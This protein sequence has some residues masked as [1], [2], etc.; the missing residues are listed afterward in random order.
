VEAGP[1][2]GFK[3]EHPDCNRVFR[4]KSGRGVHLNHAHKDWSDSRLLKESCPKAKKSRW[5]EEEKRLLARRVAA[6]TLESES[7][8]L[9]INQALAPFFPDRTIEA[10]KGIRKKVEH[11]R[12]VSELINEITQKTDDPSSTLDTSQSDPEMERVEKNNS[13]DQELEI[14]TYIHSLADIDIVGINVKALNDICNKIMHLEKQA[15]SEMIEMYVRDI[16]P[17]NYRNK[18]Q[19]EHTSTKLSSKKM[20]RKKYARVQHL[21]A[22]DRTRA[23]KAIDADRLE[24]S[25][26]LIPIN[27]LEPYW[28]A[29]VT[30]ETDAMPEDRKSESVRHDLW[31]PILEIELRRA[32]P[33]NKSAPGP[34]GITVRE[35]KQTPVSVLHRIFNIFMVRGGLPEFLLKSRTIFIDKKKDPTSPAD[36]RPISITPVLT[37]YFHEIIANRLRTVEIDERQRA[38]TNADGCS[39][40]ICLLD[41]ALRHARRTLG[42]VYLA[43]TDIAKAYDSVSFKALERTMLLKGLPP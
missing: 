12:L 4:T 28:R 27:I 18:N 34:D 32:F 35:I 20:R 26:K 13:K 1:S 41:V 33:P 5:T 39:E 9:A 43:S 7:K 15:L 31:D 2:Q 6:L 29:L 3:C 10:I 37:R 23:W 14:R 30:I 16:L 19:R 17:P 21:W 36:L 25:E 24:K 38:F 8:I 11:Q 40:N 22:K 42:S